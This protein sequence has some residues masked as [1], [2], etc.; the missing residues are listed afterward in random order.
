MTNKSPILYLLFLGIGLPGCLLIP[1]IYFPVTH[2][3]FVMFTLW[4]FFICLDIF[5]MYALYHSLFLIIS[6]FLPA[7]LPSDGVASVPVAVLY[8]TK[9]DFREESVLSCLDQDYGAFKVFILDDSD[10]PEFIRKIDS[11][12][13]AHTAV[14]IIRRPEKSGYKAGNLNFALQRIKKDF[15]AFAV[16]DSDTLFPPDFLFRTVPLLFSRPDLGFVQAVVRAR[17]GTTFFSSVLKTATDIHWKYYVPVKDAFGFTM[18]YGHSA[19]IR[20]KAWD[21]TSGF[22][23][24]V[25]EDLAFSS[26]LLEH[27][28]RG[29]LAPWVVCFEEH[30]STY[31]KFLKRG[32]KWIKGTLEYLFRYYPRV[33]RC[34]QASFQEKADIVISAGVLF[35]SLPFAAYIFLSS[36]LLPA[37]LKTFVY[38]LPV[39]FTLPSS[40]SG[41]LDYVEKIR[42]VVPWTPGFTLFMFFLMAAPFL[43]AAAFFIRKP[44][45]FLTYCCYTTSVSLAAMPAF[46]SDIIG[47]L[48]TRKTSFPVTGRSAGDARSL[49]IELAEG[50]ISFFLLFITLATGNLWLLIL[51]LTTSLSQVMGRHNL[52]F[53]STRILA[54]VPF[55]F[56]IMIFCLIWLKLR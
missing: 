54:A 34:K 26:L 20:T 22:P 29:A 37:V 41:M 23:E 1:W 43:S 15:T 16:C 19:V 25:T 8:T 45:R 47:F 32:R 36:L 12:A 9:D 51:V 6:F 52:S 30:P 53:R 24:I 17:E 55:L 13:H 42:Y 21:L 5:W 33:L 3:V 31:A 49:Q 10:T 35:L 7:R 11:F 28:M 38:H 44:F 39:F 4:L 18:F 40:A 14:S 27:G 2:S 48:I 56:Q 50:V 46:L